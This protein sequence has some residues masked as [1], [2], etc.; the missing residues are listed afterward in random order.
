RETGGADGADVKEAEGAVEGRVKTVLG[1]KGK[2]T[3][4][5]FHRELGRIMWDLC[6]MAR[7]RKSLETALQ[8][9]P[10]LREEFW[11]NV[12]V[13]GEDRELNQSLEGAARGAGF[14][15]LGRR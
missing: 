4:T 12:D 10:A 6:G 11:R 14:L 1:I 9:I 13:L 15:E 7:T 8:K 3:V 2:R 5:S